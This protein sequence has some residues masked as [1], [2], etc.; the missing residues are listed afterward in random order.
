MTGFLCGPK[1]YRYDGLFFEVHS[2]CGPHPLK[3]DGELKKQAGRKFWK[4]VEQFQ[5]LTDKEKS[6]YRIGGGCQEF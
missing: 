2:Y 6:T 4:M 1:L 5:A 3:A